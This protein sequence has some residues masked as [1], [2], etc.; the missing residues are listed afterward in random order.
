MARVRPDPAGT[1]GAFPRGEGDDDPAARLDAELGRLAD[2]LRS[3]RE[4]SAVGLDALARVLAAVE[5]LTRGSKEIE[6]VPRSLRVLGMTTRIESSRAPVPSSAGMLAET[7]RP[8]VVAD[9]GGLRG[10]GRDGP[11]RFRG[12]HAEHRGRGRVAAAETRPSATVRQ[13]ENCGAAADARAGRSARAAGSR[14]SSEVGRPGE[15]PARRATA[16]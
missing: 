6:D 5:A 15:V 3:S 13:A 8:R 10:G 7:R 1:R 11:R 14:T 12:R 2:Y 4:A 16:A 9:A